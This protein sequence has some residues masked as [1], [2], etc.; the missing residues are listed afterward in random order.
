MAAAGLLL[1]VSGVSADRGEV[2][3]SSNP[4]LQTEWNGGVAVSDEARTDEELLLTEN[5]LLLFEEF[6]GLEELEEGGGKE[7]VNMSAS[8]LEALVEEDIEIGDLLVHRPAYESF[9][10]G[11][12]ERL[13]SKVR[14]SLDSEELSEYLRFRA[15][16]KLLY[17]REGEG[18]SSWLR[19]KRD[20]LHLGLLQTAAD[21]ATD[22]M[23]SATE[24]GALESRLVRNIDIDYRTRLGN[25]RWDLGLSALGALREKADDAVV[26]QLRGFASEGS[27]RGA[28]A[29]LI[30]RRVTERNALL[31]VNLFLDYEDNSDY[32]ADFW[33][34]SYG[35]EY[36]SSW[37]DVYAN[38]YLVLTDAAR[39]VEGAEEYRVYS[40]D[41]YDV[42][43][44]L[45]SPSRRWLTGALTYY[46]FKGEFGQ[47]DD[48]GL[49]YGLRIEPL[50]G[51]GFLGG[52][53]K[54]ELELDDRIGG[55]VHLG[56]R[57]SYSYAF[58]E[59]I[60]GG[61][62]GGE[63]F[64]PRDYFY[65]PVRREYSQRI[66]RVLVNGDNDSVAEVVGLSGDEAYAEGLIERVITT[67]TLKVG[68]RLRAENTL[69]LRTGASTLT[70]GSSRWTL[71]L[72]ADT[73]LR[74]P[75]LGVLQHLGG[76][77]SLHREGGIRVLHAAGTTV[78]LL[79]TALRVEDD[80]SGLPSLVL[81]E[82]SVAYAVT[83][84]LQLYSRLRGG[85]SYLADTADTANGL[86]LTV[87][88]ELPSQRRPQGI[89]YGNTDCLS[90]TGKVLEIKAD[91]TLSIISRREAVAVYGSEAL[92]TAVVD[93]QM[94]TR[95]LEANNF[96]GFGSPA[97]LT[98]VGDGSV[99]IN[100]GGSLVTLTSG[101]GLSCPDSN[102]YRLLTALVFA[103]GTP[104]GL[105]SAGASAWLAT[106]S[107]SETDVSLNVVDDSIVSVAGA[108][109]RAASDVEYELLSLTGNATNFVVGEK[110]GLLS[111]TS[112]ISTAA[113]L[114]LS[115]R[116]TSPSALAAT[117]LVPVTVY[118][119]L[120]LRAY[121]GLSGST[122]PA[123]FPLTLSANTPS[124]VALL[125]ASGG[126]GAAYTLSLL[127]AGGVFALV[128]VSATESY[129]SLTATVLANMTVVASVLLGD[130]HAET[131][132]VMAAYTV[133]VSPAPLRLVARDSRGREIDSAVR[134]LAGQESFVASLFASGGVGSYS[135]LQVNTPEIELSPRGIS[136][137]YMLRYIGTL[138]APATL[139]AIF[140]LSDG[141]GDR[142][143]NKSFTVVVV[144]DIGYSPSSATLT[145]G[146][147]GRAGKVVA[148]LTPSDIDDRHNAALLGGETDV[149]VALVSG[150]NNQFELSVS[151]GVA[152]RITL[153]IRG[154]KAGG[155]LDTTSTM[156]VYIE[157]VP[158]LRQTS[159][160]TS[161]TVSNSRAGPLR[162]LSFVQD[163]VAP[164]F[165]TMS[166]TLP[167]SLRLDIAVDSSSG[168]VILIRQLPLGEASAVVRVSDALLDSVFHTLNFRVLSSLS[169]LPDLVILNQRDGER[170]A[171]HTVS[172]QGGGVKSY[173]LAGVSPSAYENSV[174]V[175]S[176]DGVVTLSASLSLGDSVSVYIQVS[177]DI[178]SLWQTLTLVLTKYQSSS[179]LNAG[180]QMLYAQVGAN[181]TA[182]RP[183]ASVTLGG[184]V[185][186]SSSA[187]LPDDQKI[188]T[189]A[190][191]ELR[192][193][194][195][196]AA[197]LY[198]ATVLLSG[199]NGNDPQ[200][201]RVIHQYV[202]E[203]RETVGSGS[204]ELHYFSE[205]ERYRS[206]D[207][208][209][210]WTMLDE[211]DFSYLSE[212]LAYYRNSIWVVTDDGTYVSADGI[213]WQEVGDGRTTPNGDDY[214]GSRL[215]V[216]NGI[217]YSLGSD[218]GFGTVYRRSDDG[219]VFHS[220]NTPSASKPM[221]EF[222]VALH[223]GRVYIVGGKYLTSRGSR[224]NRE[225][226]V[227]SD[228]KTWSV[229][230]S[231]PEAGNANGAVVSFNN[232]LLYLYGDRA[233]SGQV[234]TVGG[235]IRVAF[236]TGVAVGVGNPGGQAAVVVGPSNARRL[237]VL[238]SSGNLWSSS[239][240]KN[241]RVVNAV[242]DWKEGLHPFV[243]FIEVR[244]LAFTPAYQVVL[245]GP[246]ALTVLQS[247]PLGGLATVTASGGGGG[248]T[249]SLLNNVA[250]VVIDPDDGRI[251]LTSA[252]AAGNVYLLTAEASG[253]ALAAL[254]GRYV[255][256][257]DF[258]ALSFA[259]NVVTVEQTLGQSG[260]IYTVTAQ[261]GGVKSYGVAAVSHSVYSDIVDVG[262]ADGVVSLSESLAVGATVSVYIQVVNDI[263]GM[264][265]T[266]TLVL[267]NANFRAG[268]EV[269]YATV[270]TDEVTDRV[271]AYVTLGVEA[272]FLSS[273]LLPDDQNL[274]KLVNGRE[275]YLSQPATAG[276]YTATVLVA[277][278]NGTETQIRRVQYHYVVEARQVRL[279]PSSVTLHYLYGEKSYRSV[280]GG[281]SWTE[282]SRPPFRYVRDGAAYYQDRL[283]VV[284]DDATYASA[285]GTNWQPAGDGK[286]PNGDDGY[287]DSK[288]VVHNGNLYSLGSGQAL[289][290]VYRRSGD[291][292]VF[293]SDNTPSS[294][295]P[296][297]ALNVVSHDGLVYIVGGSDSVPTFM[298]DLWVSS[299][300]KE[301]SH[302]GSLPEAAGDGGGVV[303]F[304]NEL[305]Y[306]YGNNA[307]SGVVSTVDGRVSVA[308]GAGVAVGVGSTGA[309]AAVAFD[310]PNTKR[311]LVVGGHGN[312]NLWSSSDG[313]AW[314][315]VGG[316]AAAMPFGD[317]QDF[318]DII[319]SFTPAFIPVYQVVLNGPPALV[320]RQSPP[321]GGLATVT[322][323]GGGGGY[324]YSLLNN[325]AGVVIDENNGR[326]SLTSALAAGSLYLLTAN[327]FGM[328][329]ESLVGDYV[330]TVDFRLL[331]FAANV[332]TVGQTLGQSEAIYTVSAQYGGVKTYSI[333]AVSSTVYS[334][335]VMIG[336]ADGVV[337]LSRSLPI[338]ATV[339][340]YV[341]AADDIGSAAQ[342]LTL[343]LVNV[344]LRAGLQVLYPM[345]GSD[346]KTATPVASVTLE[347]G[348][349]LSSSALLPDGQALFTLAGRELRLLQPAA[350]GLYTAT[351][352]LSG[353]NGND[354]QIRRVQYHYVVQARQSGSFS[355]IL[356]YFYGF[357]SYRSFDGGMNWE[358]SAAP[359]IQYLR[360]GVAYYQNRIW[361]VH[362]KATY[363]SVDRPSGLEWPKVGGGQAPHGGND[364]R[365]SKLVV[366]N[367]S[368]YSL[369][370]GQALGTVY[371]Y[372]DS[373]NGWVFHSDNTPSSAAPLLALNVV[374]HDGLAYI[375]GGSDS[376]PTF[377]RD[378]WVSSDL[379]EWSHAGSLPEAARDGGAVAS[380]N[381]KLVYVYGN[382]AYSGVVST[383]GGR[384]SVAFGAGVA[385]GVGSGGGQAA[386]V[387]DS[388]N[389]ERLLV[390]GSTGNNNLWSSSDGQNW[391]VVG[392]DAVSRQLELPQHFADLISVPLP[393]FRPAY[394]VLL[395]GPPALRLVQSP[396]L[397][398]LATVRASGGGGGYTYS[399]LN[400][401]AGVAIDS[402]N[403]RISLTS[404]LSA[405]SLYLL[406]VEASGTAVGA[407]A[408]RYVLTID[409][410]LLSFAANVVTV[411]QA[412][413]QSGAIYTVSAQYGGVKTYSIVAV[414]S[415]V[416]SDRVMIGAADGVVELSRSLPIGA[417]VS[418][419]V[420][421]ADDIG[422]AAQ[423]LTL[424]LVNV[425]LNV[426]LQ[427]LYPLVG[428]DETADTPVA[429]LTLGVGVSL[430]S[431]ALLPFDQTV[432]TLAG[433]E[434]RLLQPAAAGLYTVTV[435]LSGTNG[436]DPQSR[437]VQ[438]RYVVE[439]RQIGQSSDT[440]HYLYGE[441]IYRSVD[442]GVRWT[443]PNTLPFSHVRD[444][445]A[446]Y[447]NSLWVVRENG[448]YASTDGITWQK[449]GKTPSRENDFYTNSKLV[450][451]NGTFYS[452]SALNG[453]IAGIVYRHNGNDWDFHANNAPS[454]AALS[455]FNVL[456]HDGLV[457]ILGGTNL[458]SEF[459]RDI[460]VS[461][462]L[463]E[464][465]PAGSL[466]EAAGD[467]GAVALLNNKLVY[468]Y[469]N[470]A[471]SGVVSTVGG[472]VSV[473]FGA[474]VAVGIGSGGGQ[475]A[476][477]VDLPNTK[478]LLVA[479][480]G[481]NANLWS[482][483]D[484]QNWN[485]FASDAVSRQ[486]ELPQQFADIILIPQVAFIPA[487]QVV[488][489]GPSALALLESPPLGG[490]ATVTASGGGGRHTYS[491]LNTVA[492]VTIDSGNGRISLT[493]A[494]SVGNLYLLTVEALGTAVGALAGR[495]V[496]TIDFRLL[497]FAANV[498]TVEQVA[499]QSGAIYTVSAQY[500][501]VKTYSIVAVSSTVYSD[502]VMIGAA[503]GV[504]E[505]SESLPNGAA[506]SVYVRVADD[507][508][509]AT[510]TLRLVLVN[511]NLN[512]GLQTLDVTVGANET[513]DRPV[514]LLTLGAG[515][516]LSSSALL[517]HGQTVFTLAG[518]ELR[519][520]QPAAAGLYMVTVLLSG[521]NGDDPQSRHVQYHYV[522]E[523]RQV[524]LKSSLPTLHY[525]HGE[526]S[527]RSVDGGV[528]WT[529][530]TALPFRYV[531]DGVAYYQ[532]RLWVVQDNATYASADGINWQPAGDGKTPNGDDGYRDSKLVV[533][534]GN[535]YSLG[536]GQALGTV[537]RRSGD[538]WVFHSDNTPSS[539]APL[540][541]LNVV[542][543][544][545][546]VYIVG[547]S[548]SV[549]TFM[550]D[551]WVSSDLQE[552]SHAGSLPAVAGDG[553]GVVSYNNE[554]KYAYRN[555]L[556]SGV[557]STVDGRVSVA[558]G[559]GG[560][561]IGGGDGIRGGGG[562]A[563]GAF[564]TP[565][566]KRLLVMGAYS[567]DGLWYSW[568]GRYWMHFGSNN[569]IPP[570]GRNQLFG[571]FISVF[572]P[573]FTPAYQVVLSGPSV[574]TM[575]QSSPLGGLA[576]V[577]ASGGGGGHTY[578]LLNNVA[579]VAIDSGNG[580]IS[581]TSALAAGSL[582]LLTVEASGTAVGALSGRY[583]VTID[584]R[585]L[586]FAESLLTMDWLLLPGMLHTV[587]AQY[588]GVKTYSIV[589]VSSTVYS[590]RVMI[591]AVD[592]VVA[593]SA[594]L[595]VDVTVSVYIRVADD[596]G[597]TAQTLT[598]VLVNLRIREVGFQTLYAPVGAN[599]MEDTP[600][601]SLTLGA[602]VTLSGSALLPHG[603]GL[604]TLAG[605]ELRLLQPAAAGLYTA[606]VS[607]SG[608]NGDDRRLRRGLY[609]YVVE[610]RQRT[611][612]AS[613]TLYRL[614]DDFDGTYVYRSVDAG[615]S[616]TQSTI[617]SI[618]DFDGDAYYYYQN[619]LWVVQNNG[620]YA[621]ADGINWQ[622]A[623]D[624]KTPKG[625]SR[626]QYSRLIEH[627]G[628]LYSLGSNEALGTVY[629][630]SGSGWVFHSDN[631]PSASNR[632]RGFNVVSHDGLVYII[633]GWDSESFSVKPEVWV[634]S[635]LKEWS[636]A[637]SLAMAK[638][639]RVAAGSFNNKLF[640]YDDSK[641]Y[642]GV[643]STVNGNINVSFAAG[644]SLDAGDDDSMLVE[645]VGPPNARRLLMLDAYGR[646]LWSSSDG[647]H[648]SIVQL[649][650]GAGGR[651]FA[652]VE[653]ET[654][655][656]A[657]AYQVL[658]SGPSVLT[659]AQ[660][661]SLG[662]LATVTAS[663]GGGDYTYS[664]LNTDAG[665]VI[666]ENNGRISLTSA[667]SAG[668][669]YLLTAEASGTGLAALS[670]RY[671][672]TVD[673]VLPLSFAANVVTVEQTMGQSGEVY[674][675]S[676]QNGGVKTYS[677]AAVSPTV[678]SNSVTIGAADGVVSLS[679][680]L[681]IGATVS[682]YVRASD[683]IGSAAQTLTLVLANIN[684]KSGMQA[685]YR[686]VRSN[687][688]A[689]TPVALV[690]LGAG[691]MLSNVALSWQ[692]TSQFTL[693]GNELYLFGRVDPGVYTAIVSL[694][695]TN[696]G[697]S[698]L[699][700]SQHQY[701]VEARYRGANAIT[702][703]YLQGSI[704][705][706]SLDEGVN[707]QMHGTFAGGE[708]RR[709]GA[710]YYQGLLWS[711]QELETQ[712]SEKGDV[713]RPDNVGTPN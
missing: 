539:A 374:S 93:G 389:G 223:D 173:L 99:V 432:F 627:N 517:P 687:E 262:L 475:V 113:L 567:S 551:I 661:P 345:V 85:V 144:D 232:S 355:V 304:N 399:L 338:D 32:N 407:L 678:Y 457:Y 14:S 185:M 147:G 706:R 157:A 546:L 326:I 176:V 350:E 580:R 526:E 156:S 34:W 533:H 272:T 124:A 540:L 631:T 180:L 52:D 412:A 57:L 178:G 174:A 72:E 259:A 135:L 376:M 431:S 542:S 273:A 158:R 348:V 434:L 12:R 323:S 409:F 314:N 121:T 455:A 42:E 237:L 493:S 602:E 306:V 15:R 21:Y 669:L 375:V 215:V 449:V 403:G 500:G 193:S 712:I 310:L 47:S 532:D 377:M 210:S 126:F 54:V 125:R 513:A 695:G 700:R 278:M 483:S 358:S 556:Y 328:A 240:G 250:G 386:V 537:Y 10:Y 132:A 524:R 538:G 477:V 38:H 713:W 372:S 531:R 480:G 578:S 637:G 91:A 71:G 688:T 505:L 155:L 680:S 56:G 87:G 512:V 106:L 470:K 649:S 632:L 698:Q 61:Y 201:R 639:E 241:W 89:G 693:V 352:L 654:P 454:A 530:P 251:S 506:M 414:S 648:W 383:V 3:S 329:V 179:V 401:V 318:A 447:Q 340:V 53:L 499:G 274:F 450:V 658:L 11:M 469:D 133:V 64:D 664:L 601:A 353:T 708:H 686:A 445:A 81:F 169:L 29:G 364:Y 507:I 498:V 360:D 628:T 235:N 319:P 463:R 123:V 189:L 511:I 268:L 143:I 640:Y 711:V 635:D 190:G 349:S 605:R 460:W 527:Y 261:G 395:S 482:S 43:L 320:V 199:T 197:G 131:E 588:G 67:K 267:A 46:N 456:S 188:F 84:S 453:G 382:R 300:L 404:S 541:A 354:R 17:N 563:V 218:E 41:G 90:D 208:G 234:S 576:T 430:S 577:T 343:V 692:S 327:A 23:L 80:G 461:S 333:V 362:D 217:L 424:A 525:L 604:F 459:Q 566:M 236:D 347:A 662:G 622:Q 102:C 301:W 592:G 379:K 701:V 408:G 248:Y 291:G 31:G 18:L 467:G 370:S 624:G 573:A 183:V 439:A 246:P 239:D 242:V 361:M 425:N 247:P 585:L 27:S 177:D 285:D 165:Y 160:V 560:A 535:L 137:S 271:L 149:D 528:S 650:L 145:L 117:L 220:D 141:S 422:S 440:L 276:L 367:G 116:A 70:V 608:M 4:V 342:T 623:G 652:L 468:V 192:L 159:E 134:V 59:P 584:F 677:L 26:W 397:G 5:P 497:S 170:R 704:I 226:W 545:G 142:F 48:K 509:S 212:G 606:T 523:A 162:Q 487:Y 561:L 486:L 324:T 630:R 381:N 229:A 253:T 667:L 96:Y 616:W 472:R 330:V 559:A 114:T 437:R 86:N 410:R 547:G 435:L 331:S 562:Q 58:N 225:V 411:E 515:V 303:S 166:E 599:E 332:V 45:H 699:R 705:Y 671:V 448:T 646:E 614:G 597:S 243:G 433:R 591:G 492:G 120:S 536:S 321:L 660:S 204:G 69:T 593:L 129:L 136:S 316:N 150:S 675:V 615:L 683:N 371:R 100:I 213:R 384:V 198:T 519:L 659:V 337:K 657:P 571:D 292:W 146:I 289:G 420:R 554:L 574:L 557:V 553:G 2:A 394:Q 112:E 233:Y 391:S 24:T 336:E 28:N 620:T 78:S 264:P 495:Y 644:V 275:L 202:V 315:V 299:D 151:G 187:L 363:A 398:G 119:P 103:E 33:R 496:L 128:S 366:H 211:T 406:T 282:L 351:V 20:D 418:V 227:S 629:R 76:T 689:D 356:Y 451:H 462:D 645:V 413:G 130:G 419:Y 68:D 570:F 302:A 294:A 474:G 7:S 95:W 396:P 222:N 105:I 286:T 555:T 609:R 529:G 209:V 295:A 83:S 428:A 668:S 163:G 416:Y 40:R 260:A 109:L 30:Y 400:T 423:T 685:L 115:V 508:G 426:G 258:Q 502:R 63:G 73:T 368:L 49:R 612:S 550:R 464:W 385:V 373:D 317:A 270:G 436:G 305:V 589:A 296:L 388:L 279:K 219:W 9:I 636:L 35:G 22:Y 107:V 290:T 611:K 308:F 594:P 307:Y 101:M 249:Y 595:S 280:D 587:S 1:T 429:S 548:D 205:Y 465:A 617:S 77:L 549:P 221:F 618:F 633:G 466:P 281:T 521:T 309:Q 702:L 172:T 544:D 579:G 153:L 607:L 707:W 442:G 634:S 642:S 62:L 365:D 598:L 79:G 568:N 476:V 231:L 66:S 257:V 216:H 481:G 203:A 171:L 255:V 161:L 359:D 504:V 613:L 152:R 393:I 543:H 387:V 478:R 651:S 488:L 344:N 88:C 603:Q 140:L 558:F 600:V 674:T 582:Y 619:S 709:D 206:V 244:T 682:V 175:G 421:A 228:L 55:G 380:L 238:G 378:I 564:D 118:T 214:L 97:E 691:V 479:G 610:A 25:R 647:Q 164:Y 277:G 74:F 92:L 312:A 245:N 656:F 516:S 590:D 653:G 287:R 438:Y 265:Q 288:L 108:S 703:Y 534:N 339:S 696:D 341:R 13:K 489:S 50:S 446:Y 670:G 297:L 390:L 82:G 369:G 335:R 65:E 37:L 94:T 168:E 596:I 672:V 230:G 266:L 626:Y 452:L 298:R 684:L 621:S 293:H 325:V 625:T 110:T 520:V 501:G 710:A 269:V 322:A 402:G 415:T 19:R 148:N 51:G 254:A 138:E 638:G 200:L 39:Q 575:V 569:L 311:L 36:R 484:G 196:A 490:L 181:E 681:P 473:A 586:S 697:D 139:V 663:G 510:Q 75:S 104:S 518:R 283:W 186:L 471:Y 16:E 666:D 256:T 485:V 284:Q 581:L 572:I 552:W 679:E 357:K 127:S 441:K 6:E 191:R 392:G 263:G 655:A 252:L 195:P 443:G 154:S 167:L 224:F 641:F 313:R 194:Q 346:E 643:V 122:T 444:G 565:N 182:D 111:L 334:D 405:G 690:T 491:L 514:A 184:G 676:A 427:I 494:L 98:L 665:V 417:A 8:E 458:D 522:V 673:F 694:S 60:D 583:V 503:D 207:E 44:A